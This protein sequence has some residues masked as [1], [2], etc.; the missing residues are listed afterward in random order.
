MIATAKAVS[1]TKDGEPDGWPIEPGFHGELDFGGTT[2]LMLSVPTSFLERVHRDLVKQLEPPLGVLYRQKID[3]RNPRPEGASPRDH[4]ALE[5]STQRVLDSLAACAGVVYHDA[6]C[7]LWVRGRRG[8][9]LILDSD[10][11][12][13]CYPDDPLFRDVARLYGLAEGKVTTLLERDYVKHHYD[14]HN[15]VLEDRLIDLLHL[16]PMAAQ[17]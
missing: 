2:R 4:V 17:R 3:R 8:E 11:L 15:D 10:G 14:A 1:V 6:R 13:F 9:Q 7:E 12:I 5:T 16:E